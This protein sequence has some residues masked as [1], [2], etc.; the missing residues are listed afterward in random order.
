MW[1]QGAWDGL[2][3][4]IGRINA[5]EITK[6]KA[7]FFET[8]SG[9]TTTG[10]V[11]KPAG[12]GPDVDF[13]MDE[14][15]T[16][17]DAL[18]STLAEGK[19][20]FISPTDSGG[21]KITTT[22]DT[23]G[24]FT[25]SGTPDPADD[26]ALI[27]VYT[28]Y[29][30]N[31]DVE[32]SLFE[33]E[34]LGLEPHASSHTDGTDDIQNA[35]NSQKGLATAAQITKLEGIE[36]SA[37][38]TDAENVGN[39]IHDVASK[40]TPVD[41]DELGLID[42]AA[43]YV[44]K[45]LTW[46]NLKTT[47]KTYFDGIYRIGATDK[48]EQSYTESPMVVSGGEVTE[49]T[50]AGTFK[51][52]ALT[53]LLRTTDS[54][55]GEL[56]KVTKGLE[57]NIT[58]TAADTTYYVSLNYNAGSPT[59]SLSASNPYEADKRNIPIGKV[60]KDASNNVHY[61]SGGF[62]FQDGVKKSHQRAKELRE[63][64]LENGST[65]A[66]SGTNNFTMTTG[67]VYGGL[68][69]FSLSAYDSAVTQFTM[70]YSDGADGWTEVD[71][72]TI[73]YAH[74]D[75]GSGTL[76]NI[77]NNKYGNHYVY[78]HISDE[79]V[80]VVLGTDSYT[81]AEAV[82]NAVISPAI[83]THLDDFGCL[84]GCIIAPQAGG[85]FTKIVMVTSQFFSGVEASDHANLAHLDFASSGH[86]GFVGSGANIGDN[87]LVRGDGGTDGVQECSTITVDD[88]GRMVN[89]GQPKFKAYVNTT[90]D[91]VTGDDTLYSVTGSFW[92]E[93]TDDGNNFSNGIFT[94]P[95]DGFYQFNVTMYI[96]GI[97]SSSNHKRFDL[98]LNTSNGTFSLNRLVITNALG[99]LAGGTGSISI[100]LDANDTAYAQINV[101]NDT[102]VIDLSDNQ[103]GFSGALIC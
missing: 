53:A 24:N 65:I 74:Y 94:A 46:T 88:N 32:E 15:G 91:N 10:K 5:L 100:Y 31:F 64:E 12:A 71:R 11:S 93:N 2:V 97:V 47:L 33:A 28:C 77:G 49:G 17:T 102:K 4:L 20:T 101:A 48:E 18:L 52:A 45:K 85:S 90:Q 30:S 14:W 3:A 9:G 78:K 79:H 95:V 50:N 13:V 76:A 99:G 81:L 34:L 73:D 22:F 40:A 67:V 98:L 61:I 51:V 25:F 36:A 8:I 68:N 69:R 43:S 6:V 96:Q 59:I 72:N 60:R 16:A 1:K 39:S 55:T 92:T 70:L 27:Y 56:E 103:S 86:T 57:D 62:R 63:L 89:T 82:L 75:D 38:V 80:Y 84:I 37:D 54:L 23:E 66:Y 87:K 42:S 29:L 26:V 41:A 35:T 21:N 58:I 44:L 19:P 83:P 7:T